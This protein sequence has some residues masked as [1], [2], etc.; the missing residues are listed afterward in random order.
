MR[1]G[2]TK[3]KG[4]RVLKQHHGGRAEH[5]GRAACAQQQAVNDTRGAAACC[6]IWAAPQHLPCGLHHHSAPSPQPTPLPQPAPVAVGVALQRVGPQAEAALWC[7]VCATLPFRGSI[8][9]RC[10][11][12][13]RCC[14]AAR[15]AAAAH[16]AEG[17][18]SHAAFQPSQAAAAAAQAAAT[19][20]RRQRGC[21]LLAHAPPR[22]E[23]QWRGVGWR[24]A[25]LVSLM[26]VPAASP[27]SSG[28]GRG[29]QRR[30]I[31]DVR[32]VSKSTAH[33]PRQRAPGLKLAARSRS[34]GP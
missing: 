1:S 4:Q 19:A 15:A 10:A 30:F 23:L 11:A 34:A 31:S 14:T 24:Q 7:Q 9:R 2:G 26:Y 12:L 21:R 18:V 33:S 17:Q 29:R 22:L 5:S 6:C 8:Q 25:V 13:R 32:F 3:V 27:S 16:A 28:C 20:R